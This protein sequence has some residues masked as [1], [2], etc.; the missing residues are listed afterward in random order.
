MRLALLVG[1]S[2]LL[3]YLIVFE[4]EF[5]GRHIRR[6]HAGAT[7]HPSTETLLAYLVAFALAA[8][9]LW[10][11][12]RIDGINGPALASVVVLAFP[13]SLGAALGRMLV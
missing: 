11:F 13:A 6:A 4:A 1:M 7:Q 3:P 10:T 8:G 12:G 5:G 2:L 9:M